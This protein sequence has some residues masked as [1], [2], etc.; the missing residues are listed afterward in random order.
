MQIVSSSESCVAR[1]H[2]DDDEIEIISK[3]S[4]ND[5]VQTP[6][7]MTE[8]TM[9]LSSFVRPIRRTKPSAPTFEEYL[10]VE[11]D[12]IPKILGRT[13]RL[14]RPGRKTS[15]S[16]ASTPQAVTIGEYKK[17]RMGKQLADVDEEEEQS[18]LGIR[19]TKRPMDF[20]DSSTDEGDD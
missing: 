9:M 20:I 5:P 12:T 1:N 4:W 8:T 19:A 3:K 14:N 2:D 11:D 6:N 16:D 18:R 7:K 10:D 13:A 15:S 17:S